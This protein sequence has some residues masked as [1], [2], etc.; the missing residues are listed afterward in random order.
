MMKGSWPARL[1]ALLVVVGSVGSLLLVFMIAVARL[2]PPVV[3]ANATATVMAPPDAVYRLLST[4]TLQSSWRKDVTSVE[5]REQGGWLEHGVHGETT[6][7]TVREASPGLT[8]DVRLQDDA[9]GWDAT[10]RVVLSPA[11]LGTRL[12]VA[13]ATT[14]LGLFARFAA[15]ALGGDTSQLRAWLKD[16]EGGLATPPNP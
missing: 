12:E 2:V 8:W 16:L 1:F 4:A 15:V 13:Q 3:E 11:P 5:P 9:H 7:V 14:H 6:L 10:R